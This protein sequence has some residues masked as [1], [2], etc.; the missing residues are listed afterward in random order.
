MN[1]ILSPLLGQRLTT[2]GRAEPFLFKALNRGV[3][4]VVPEKSGIERSFPLSHVEG[5]L[6]ELKARGTICL[7][8]IR[9]HSEMNPV[10]IAALLSRL[11]GVSHVKK[12]KITLLWT[13]GT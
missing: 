8:D 11:P 7:V 9:R 3:I 4:T 1:D 13:S 2:L 12:P 10:Y 5:A 6:E